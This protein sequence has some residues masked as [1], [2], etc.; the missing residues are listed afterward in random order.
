MP[1]H[2]SSTC[3]HR[4]EIKIVL[5]SLWYHQTYR[6]PS[7]ARKATYRCEDTRDCIIQFC[8]PDG[9]HMCSKHVEASNKLIV[10]F[11][12]SSWLIL[13]NH[14][15]VFIFTKFNVSRLVSYL[16]TFHYTKVF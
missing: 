15:E 1:L 7:R 11:S 16:L 14:Y 9:E 2:V 10:K 8:P 13:R 6:W 5:Y 4:Q 12:A 3:A